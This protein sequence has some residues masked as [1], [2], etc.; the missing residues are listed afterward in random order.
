MNSLIFTLTTS[1][2]RP[3]S[4]ELYWFFFMHRWFEH[5]VQHNNIQSTGEISNMFKI[6]KMM[7]TQWEIAK[8]HRSK[9][10]I[11]RLLV[12]FT[13]DPSNILS[14]LMLDKN[15]NQKVCEGQDHWKWNHTNETRESLPIQIHSKI[16]SSNIHTYITMRTEF[17]MRM[18]KN[19]TE[20]KVSAGSG[21]TVAAWAGRCWRHTGC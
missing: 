1:K 8:L 14:A 7:I 10:F 20:A 18:R 16:N 4:N 21:G 17:E 9:R 12:C 13:S 2:N 6:M 3:R 5:K 19:E 15:K 11:S